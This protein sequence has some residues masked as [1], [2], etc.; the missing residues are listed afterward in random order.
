MPVKDAMLGRIEERLRQLGVPLAIT[1]WDGKRVTA[2][3]PPRVN[4]TVRSPAALASLA[5][6]TMGKLARHYVEEQLDVDGE[7]RQIIRVSE[8]LSDS[9]TAS[10][11]RG[12]RLRKWIGHSRLFDSKA[13][14]Y[15]YDVSDDFF[16]L[17]LD[18]R[19]VYSCGY[20]RRADDTLAIAQ[21]QKLDHICRKLMLKPGDRFLDIGCGWGALILWAAERYKVHA[22]GITLSQNQYDYARQ[23]IAQAG[24]SDRCEVRLLDYR[25]VPEDAPYDRIA[26]VGMFEHVGRK[27]LPVYFGK[28][29][30]LLKPG[31]LVMN[32]GITLNSVD[33]QELGSDIGSFIDEYVFP[34]G[35]LTHV[36]KV[37]AEMSQQGLESWD[38]ESLRPHYARTLWSWVENLEANRAAALQTVTEKIYRIW[39]IY[40]AGSAHAFERGWMSIYQILG[41]RALPDGRLAV[42]S[43]RD[44]IYAP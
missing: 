1:L 43:S 9:P 34:G 35:E 28:I 23:R 10:H 4:V 12:S 44:Y 24:L 20:F 27:N 33:G 8:A 5:Q 29:Y 21:E 25:D 17:W 38:V 26:S 37:I 3:E 16:G 11:A 41:G 30:R 32:H 15:H 13:I 14:R 19:R 22:T 39:R 2:A 40:M 6:P 7:A 36:S 42:P 18:P 31:G